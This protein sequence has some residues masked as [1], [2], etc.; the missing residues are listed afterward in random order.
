MSQLQKWVLH[1]AKVDRGQAS[2]RSA[3]TI[4]EGT[5]QTLYEIPVSL[6]NVRVR[7]H[8]HTH[9]GTHIH[10]WACMRTYTCIHTATTLS[11]CCHSHCQ[12]L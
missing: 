3:Q 7:A 5:R 6:N 12:F 9:A 2:H 11:H 1:F 10:M 4:S 8:T